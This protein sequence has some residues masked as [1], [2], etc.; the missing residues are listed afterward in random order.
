MSCDSRVGSPTRFLAHS[1]DA[2]GEHTV[3]N[4]RWTIDILVYPY[5]AVTQASIVL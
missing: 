3:P 2:S 5:F 4:V 1:E